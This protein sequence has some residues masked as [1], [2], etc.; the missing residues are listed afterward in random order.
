MNTQRLI[1]LAVLP[2]VLVAC[3]SIPERNLAVE[4]A[5]SRFNAASNYPQ[6]VTLAPAE[7]TNAGES[8][9]IAE[10]AQRGGMPRDRVDHL[11]YIAMQRIAIAQD[12]ADDRASQAVTA[13]AGAERDKM[14]LTQRTNEA[15]LAKQQLAASERTSARKSNEL[16]AA[17][18]AAMQEKARNDQRVARRD[19]RVTDLETQLRALNAEKTDRGMVLTLGDVLFDSG[20]SELL[21][22]GSH[23]M[24]KLAGFF[25]RNPNSTASIEG[26]TDS[27]GSFSSNMELSRRRAN[28]VMAALVSLGVQANHLSTKA[29][30][31]EQPTASNDTAAGRRMNRRVEIVFAPQHEEVS[32]K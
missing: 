15:D 17:D 10:Q 1:A 13:G 2:L 7:L 32:L 30:G 6:V 23:S 16:A 26:Y 4:Q 31:E 18:A 12:T 28:V 8:L 19:T 29:H 11:A 20:Q 9:Q 25:Q 14:R 24:V 21:P 5:R 3:G 27:V 22:D